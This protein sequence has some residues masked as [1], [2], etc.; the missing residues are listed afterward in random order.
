V[1]QFD[2]TAALQAHANQQI[3]LMFRG[4][5]A[6]LAGSSGF[7]SQWFVDDASLLVY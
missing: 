3:V 2:L 6:N 4:T 7:F 1:G 5:A